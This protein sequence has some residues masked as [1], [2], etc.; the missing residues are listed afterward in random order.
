MQNKLVEFG[1]KEPAFTENIVKWQ[2]ILTNH[3]Q[4]YESAKERFFLTASHLDSNYST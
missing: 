4:L 2:Q 1:D 3:K